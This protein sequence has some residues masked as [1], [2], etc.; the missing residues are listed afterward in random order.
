MA[1]MKPTDAENASNVLGGWIGG[2]CDVARDDHSWH[3]RFGAAGSLDAECPWRLIVEGRIVL[4]DADD[5][6]RFGLPAPVDALAA[7]RQWLKDRTITAVVVAEI[8]GDL[9]IAFDGGAVLELLNTSSGYE[10]WNGRA[11]RPGQDAGNVVAMGGGG[12]AFF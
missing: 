11:Q 12:L 9:K 2:T 10:A 5:D 4:C 8:T 1:D 3:F 7:A 6:Q